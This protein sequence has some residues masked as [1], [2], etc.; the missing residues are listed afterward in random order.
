MSWTALPGRSRSRPTAALVFN[1]NLSGGIDPNVQSSLTLNGTGSVFFGNNTGVASGSA[2]IGSTGGIVL[3]GVNST[4]GVGSASF[5]NSFSGGVTQ[6]SGNMTIA[7]ASTVTTVAGIV[8]VASGPVGTGTLRLN[9]GLVRVVSSTL[10]TVRNNLVLSGN[11]T[12]GFN[13]AVPGTSRISLS[14]PPA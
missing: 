6:N 7:N 4:M 11:V 9:G 2:V 12:F 14:I 3:N 1:S 5:I 8:S 10:K 13:N